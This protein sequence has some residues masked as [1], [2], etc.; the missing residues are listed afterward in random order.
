MF[1]NWLDR[2][3]EGRAQRGEE[4]KKTTDL[5]LDADRAFPGMGAAETVEE[6]CVL[7]ET[8]AADPDFLSRLIQATKP[9][10]FGMAG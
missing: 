10:S 9:L 8:A 1:H 4:A 7:A 3:D 5:I 2:W 6:L